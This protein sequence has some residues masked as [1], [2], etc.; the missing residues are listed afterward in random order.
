MSL[1]DARQCRFQG[2]ALIKEDD[3]YC[4]RHRFLVTTFGLEKAQGLERGFEC[5]QC[6]RKAEEQC[7]DCPECGEIACSSCRTAKKCCEIA[8]IEERADA[9]ERDADEVRTEADRTR[10]KLRAA[11]SSEAR[12]A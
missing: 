9:L 10:R 5:P 3:D 1:H 12:S 2:C 6:E 11:V 7:E 4:P 8:E